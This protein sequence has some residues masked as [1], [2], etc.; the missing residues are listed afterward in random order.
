MLSQCLPGRPAEN[1]KTPVMTGGVWA[2]IQTRH[3]LNICLEY[4][5]YVVVV[6]FWDVTTC[7]LVDMYQQPRRTCCQH[8]C[9][10]EVILMRMWPVYG[11]I[12]VWG[13]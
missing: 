10:V 11:D 3:P 12:H 9:C 1:H 7:S 2:E 5:C 4:Y 6:G 8:L 13:K